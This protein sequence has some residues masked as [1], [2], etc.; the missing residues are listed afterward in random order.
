[1]CSGEFGA[2]AIY[3]HNEIDQSIHRHIIT[4]Y[5]ETKL[6]PLQFRPTNV[7]ACASHI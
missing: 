7:R 5:Y 3:G 4:Y 2:K 1:M 6:K